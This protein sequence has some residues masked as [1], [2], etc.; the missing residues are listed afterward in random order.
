M[1]PRGTRV[2][3]ERPG[4]PRAEGIVEQD[5][6]AHGERVMYQVRDDRGTVY[7][8]SEDVLAEANS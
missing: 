4:L 8:F 3:W 5:R 1:Y 2:T 7:W 6:L